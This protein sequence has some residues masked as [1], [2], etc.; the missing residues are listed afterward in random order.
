[1]YGLKID[2]STRPA[3]QNSDAALVDRLD[4]LQ[5]K[6]PGLIKDVAAAAINIKNTAGTIKDATAVLALFDTKIETAQRAY[7]QGATDVAQCEKSCAAKKTEARELITHQRAVTQEII[8]GLIDEMAS[9][10]EAKDTALQLRDKEAQQ[11]AAE[12]RIAIE[13][14]STQLDDAKKQLNANVAK[15]LE[16][17]E[18]ARDAALKNDG[19]DVET[20][21]RLRKELA[22]AK[23]KRDLVS[24]FRQLVEDYMQFMADAWTKIDELRAAQK[25][26]AEAVIEREKERSELEKAFFTRIAGL[27][28]D[29]ETLEKERTKI[30]SDV[31]TIKNA[32]AM[33]ENY[34][35][36]T[37]RKLAGDQTA[38]A[39]T[40]KANTYLA[41]RKAAA[42]QLQDKGTEIRALFM[43]N[44]DSSPSRFWAGARSELDAGSGNEMERMLPN[45]VEWYMSTYRESQGLLIQEAREFAT[46][47]S[48]HRD[49]LERFETGVR[50][51]SNRLSRS[52]DA[53][54][55]FG[56]LKN[57]RVRMEAQTNSIRH[58]KYLSSLIAEH[59]IWRAQ[60]G[61]NLP[62]VSFIEA[63]RV[64]ADH[65]PK[66]SLGEDAV[67]ANLLEMLDI[68]IT[69]MDGSV[70]KRIVSEK[71]MA[72][73]SSQG[74][75]F[76]VLAIVFIGFIN[77]IRRDASVHIVWAIDELKDLSASNVAILLDTATKNN[78]TL[79][80]AFPDV[81]AGLLER[82]DYA[83]H[84]SENKQLQQIDPSL[85]G[86]G[87]AWLFS[88]EAISA[89]QAAV[90]RHTGTEGSEE[91]NEIKNEDR[92]ETQGALTG[93]EHV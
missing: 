7:Q 17:I 83:Y 56:K 50:S 88:D 75:S 70:A 27:L 93:E 64:I 90:M 48:L 1:M 62:S 24:G 20:V 84:V 82:L 22:D 21:A 45:L 46:R 74:L 80:T 58:R 32:L 12:I 13:K 63:V 72:D 8:D 67:R 35:A 36:D 39:M 18:S 4:Q 51:F 9:L 57:V 37:Q 53:S 42:K 31:R 25:K 2:L 85:I 77:M 29:Q 28:T 34:T 23:K 54:I 92:G 78:I 65:L 91:S 41:E 61:D 89:T 19:V 49:A 71:T 11:A 15:E 44:D 76:L 87:D 10:K 55:E 59:D 79:C 26:S 47:L 43:K 16:S 5:A 3:S 33:L 69:L 6:L 81:D 86:Q 68:E 14:E 52:T 40:V 66:A 60:P 30:D 38:V 73:I